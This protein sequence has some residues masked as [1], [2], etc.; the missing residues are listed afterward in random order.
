MGFGVCALGALIQKR[1][2]IPPD[3]AD[4]RDHEHVSDRDEP[5]C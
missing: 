5:G 3:L 4:D 1:T 2:P